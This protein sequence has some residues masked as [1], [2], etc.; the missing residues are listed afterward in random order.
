M[1]TH[2]NKHTH[3]HTFVVPLAYMQSTLQTLKTDVVMLEKEVKGS[4]E[5]PFSM[6]FHSVMSTFYARAQAEI[7]RATKQFTLVEGLSNEVITSF[8]E[9]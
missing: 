5:E 9:V 1:Q 6:K 2:T 4:S 3:T 8:A 7:E